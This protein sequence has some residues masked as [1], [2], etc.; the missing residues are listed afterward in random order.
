M[1]EGAV[2]APAERLANALP[3]LEHASLEEI[4]FRIVIRI[5]VL[6]AATEGADEVPA[7]RLVDALLTLEHASLEEQLRIAFE[8][9]DTHGDGSIARENMVEILKVGAPAAHSLRTVIPSTA[10]AIRTPQPADRA[11]KVAAE[12]AGT[13]HLEI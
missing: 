12:R 2:E 9:L 11:G 6:P 8:L 10:P 1:T 5:A 4:A 13:S 3:I 7:E